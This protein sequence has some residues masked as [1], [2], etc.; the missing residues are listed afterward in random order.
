MSSTSVSS[1]FLNG[2]SETAGQIK[3]KLY[4]G[5]PCGGGSVLI[6]FHFNFFLF[7][8]SVF[9]FS[10]QTRSRFIY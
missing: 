10:D 4:L 7:F 9:S 8:S 2:I 5:P 3:T 1:A 6:F